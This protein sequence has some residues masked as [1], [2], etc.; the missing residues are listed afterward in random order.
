MVPSSPLDMS[1]SSRVGGSFGISIG[2]DAVFGEDWSVRSPFGAKDLVSELGG[3]AGEQGLSLRGGAL[4]DSSPVAVNIG[5][6]VSARNEVLVKVC[7]VCVTTSQ[8]V[9]HG[10]RYQ[11]T[12]GNR[13]GGT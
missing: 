9:G 8:R 1:L 6:P 5:I 7:R 3:F 10:T 12:T 4:F 11:L 2:N 13:S